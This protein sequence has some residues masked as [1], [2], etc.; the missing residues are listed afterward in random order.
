[1]PAQ[2][3]P[4]RAVDREL[5]AGAPTE[6]V[7]GAGH[8]RRE[9]IDRTG[10]GRAQPIDVDVA[11]DSRR[12]E[13]VLAP[14]IGVLPV[15]RAIGKAEGEGWLSE[16]WRFGRGRQTTTSARLVRLGDGFLIDSPGIGEF[17]LDPMPA[18]ELSWA[19][20]CGLETRRPS[21][22]LKS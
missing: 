10:E 7:G 2:S 17:T 1:M 6:T 5:D 12:G 4:A 14:A 13:P 18:P 15:R 21:S 8:R 9:E 20:G 3:G 11:A 16:A 22:T 19:Y